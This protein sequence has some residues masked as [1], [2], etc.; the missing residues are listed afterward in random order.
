MMQVAAAVNRQPS[1][2]GRSTAPEMEPGSPAQTAPSR[3]HLEQIQ[4]ARVAAKPIRRAVSY[5][6]LSGWSMA[7]FS[8]LT[9]AT[10]FG[11]AAGWMLGIALAAVAYFELR[12]AKQLARLDASVPQRLAINQLILGL[13]L[14]LY[15][16]WGVFRAFT[17]PSA[18]GELNN[19]DPQLKMMIGPV[20]QLEQAITGALYLA[21]MLIGLLVPAC[22]AIFYATRRH[23]LAAYLKQTPPWIVE[24]NRKGVAV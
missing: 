3:E 17:G 15:A 9:M 19:A 5:A 24:L 16:G 8:L 22:T 23:H 13:A 7:V 2:L 10:S 1:S 18:F 11:S 12:G 14:V 21:L 6:T 20:D 4:A